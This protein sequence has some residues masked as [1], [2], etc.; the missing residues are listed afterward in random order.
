MIRVP[1]E[2]EDELRRSGILIA[3]GEPVTIADYFET[4][5]LD[6]AIYGRVFERVERGRRE[7]VD[8]ATLI[9]T[10][11][12]CGR[13]FFGDKPAIVLTRIARGRCSSCR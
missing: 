3:H 1:P 7:L 12:R 10:C 2:L 8:P 4:A 11:S 13:G 6:S 5:V 9:E